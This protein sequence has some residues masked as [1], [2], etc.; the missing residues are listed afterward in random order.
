MALDIA[1]VFEMRA[2]GA[3]TNGGGYKTGASGTDFSQQD[4]AQ[5]ELT[6]GTTAGAD[7]IYLHASAAAVMVGNVCKI[8]GTNFTTGW[9]ECTSVV[10]GVSMT[11]DRNIASGVGAD[12]V[13]NVGGAVSTFQDAMFETL[14]AGNIVYVKKGTYTLAESLNVAKDGTDANGYIKIEG[15]N[16]TRGDAPLPSSTNQPYIDATETN[17]TFIFDD[18]WHFKCLEYDMGSTQTSGWAG[19]FGSIWEACKVSFYANNTT[20]AGIKCGTSL[21]AFALVLRC[22][23]VGTAANGAGVS[24]GSD[25]VIYGCVFRGAWGIVANGTQNQSYYS[26]NIFIGCVKGLY[27][28]STCYARTVTN[29]TFYGAET[30]TGIGLDLHADALSFVIKNNIFYGLTTA[31]TQASAFAYSNRAYNNCFNNNTTNKTRFTSYGDVTTDP[32]FTDAGSDD[33][34]VGSN[35]QVSESI[36]GLATLTYTELG[37]VQTEPAAAAA[38]GGGGLNICLD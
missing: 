35:M 27:A 20:T 37:A 28:N 11:F 12:G 14:V 13:C 25:A 7:A 36:G 16:A 23:L 32:T 18:M 8:S 19:D 29:N 33:F 38:A 22:E 1:C 15:Y 5:Y 2:T 9:Y 30:P 24:S 34:S 10:V 4:A 6:G 26:N 17:Y 3:T 21:A 31:I